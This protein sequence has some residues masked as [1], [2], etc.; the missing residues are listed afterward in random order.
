[1]EY[2]KIREIL[3]RYWEGETSLEEET[4]LRH[5]FAEAAPGLPAD[6]ESARPLFAYFSVNDEVPVFDDSAMPWGASSNGV[7]TLK[8]ITPLQHW[9]KYAAILLMALGIGYGARQY[10]QR[11][12]SIA[13]AA[14][15]EDTF[16]DPQK[17]LVFTQ[18]AL[19]ILA[20][21]L[22]KG[23]AQMQKLAYFSEATEKI[24]AD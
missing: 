13:V 19:R 14:M 22:N 16:D 7:H 9:M 2:N 5:F 23:T 18:K 20:K 4:A 8:S 21:N 1:M 24:K 6:L 17:A 10:Q 11:Q 12:E 15:K 3:A